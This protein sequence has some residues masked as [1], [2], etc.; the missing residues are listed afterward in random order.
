MAA[1]IDAAQL[2]V[3]VEDSSSKSRGWLR[4][5]G[6]VA[7]T[8]GS[9]R[10]R[11]KG[12]RACAHA[13]HLS[14]KCANA[15][16][17]WYGVEWD[18]VARG[19]H[20]G[21]HEGVQYFACQQPG[22]GSFVRAHAAKL[23]FGLPFVEAVHRRYLDESASVRND[24]DLT[25]RT[26]SKAAL[27]VQFVGQDK[28]ARKAAELERMRIAVLHNA[29][30]SDSTNG[31]DELVLP[32]VTE[33][34]L[35]GNLLSRWS[36]VAALAACMPN[37]TN[38]SLASNRLI[39]LGTTEEQAI[40]Q[41]SVLA[42]SADV[43]VLGQLRTLVLNDMCLDWHSL[44]A[45]LRML[46]VGLEQ[47]HVIRNQLGSCTLALHA[48]S[49]VRLDLSYNALDWPSVLAAL[50]GLPAL[51]QLNLSFNPIDR[52]TPLALPTVGPAAQLLPGRSPVFEAL[53]ELSLVGTQVAEWA[54]IEALATLPAL[55]HLRLH[56]TPLDS[57]AMPG[58]SAAS[59]G[60]ALTVRAC[61]I[62]R[63]ASLVAYNGAAVSAK[64][65]ESAE[66]GL[67]RWG[68]Q[69]PA[70]A[71]SMRFAA[72]LAV[73][74][75]QVPAVPAASSIA[76]TSVV[77]SLRYAASAGAEPVELVKRR[78]PQ[79]TEIWQVRQI[80]ENCLRHKVPEA[81]A[82]EALYLAYRHADGGLCFELDD[83]RRTVG[84]YSLED[85]GA[86]EVSGQRLIMQHFILH[87]GLVV[88]R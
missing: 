59:D 39:P 20:S 58:G 5:C 40:A 30:I 49:L 24:D 61:V 56:S 28:A 79:S 29:A 75:P 38:L 31:L 18:D 45:V 32:S 27:A 35:S 54:S 55:Q 13:P 2:P 6:P 53:C 41:C 81:G 80:A 65:R 22:A 9:N 14:S 36:A 66:R 73:H 16:G 10:V 64:E 33:C 68:A 72:L 11:W 19:R 1:D 25:L 48:D 70:T 44:A 67:L 78:I 8:Q 85:G 51:Q 21:A 42:A 7:S 63:L 34:D 77:L 37:L 4:Y 3:R 74:G 82:H 46:A 47:L 84:S 87:S 52:V 83:D 26:E 62:A 50:G 57:A 86:I 43:R 71:R 69:D 17:I 15:S 60:S 12:A 23:S 88:S 76:K